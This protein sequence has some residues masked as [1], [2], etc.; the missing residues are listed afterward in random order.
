VVIELLDATIALQ[1]QN[2]Q[3][4]QTASGLLQASASWPGT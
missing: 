2:L 1:L 3:A 4:A